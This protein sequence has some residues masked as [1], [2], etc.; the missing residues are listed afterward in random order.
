MCALTR[1][2]RSAARTRNAQAEQVVPHPRL[3]RR[4]TALRW[5]PKA[6]LELASL[7]A[8]KENSELLMHAYKARGLQSPGFFARFRRCSCFSKS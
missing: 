6:A 1:H 5:A 4:P 2:T 7:A 3:S 8:T